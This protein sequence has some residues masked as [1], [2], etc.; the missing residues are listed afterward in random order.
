MNVC[1]EKLINTFSKAY[2]LKPSTHLQSQ[3]G[4]HIDFIKFIKLL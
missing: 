2:D 1:Y 3:E 4:P